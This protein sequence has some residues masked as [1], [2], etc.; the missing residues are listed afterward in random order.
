MGSIGGVEV[1]R[2]TEKIR[3]LIRHDHK[4]KNEELFKK[5]IETM[6]EAG[7]EARKNEPK[8]SQN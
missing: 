7:K 5:L 2:V 6:R 1:L 8:L 4:P 3:A